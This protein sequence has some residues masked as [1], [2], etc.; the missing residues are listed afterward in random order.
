LAQGRG[1]G[2]ARSPWAAHAMAA[3]QEALHTLQCFTNSLNDRAGLQRLRDNLQELPMRWLSRTEQP[4]DYLLGSVRG[5]CNYHFKFRLEGGGFFQTGV[6]VASAERTSGGLPVPL[7]CKWKRRIKD[8]PVEIPGVTSN[9]YQISA[10]D[11]GTDICVEAQPADA[12]DGLF[13]VAVGEIGPFELDPA[14]RRS[15]DNAL[16]VGGSKFTVTQ[17]KSPG[18]TT[19]SNRQD[20]MIHVTAESVKV[21]PVQGGAEKTN[22]EIS[23]EYSADYPKVIIHPLDTSKFQLLMSES[24]T[25]HFAALSRTSRDLIALTIR[26]FHAKKYLSVSGILEALLPVQPMAQADAHNCRLDSCI[27]LERLTKELNRTMQQ[28]EVSEK[29]LRN[30]HNEKKQLQAQL[31][32]TISGFTEV[33]ESLQGQIVDGPLA[34]CPAVSVERLQDQLRE[35]NQQIQAHQAELQSERQR[36]EKLQ[37]KRKAA[38]A[39]GGRTPG[40]GE[41]QAPQLREERDLL[42]A[43]LMELSSSSATAGQ[44]DKADQVHAHELK[45]LR[46]D[47]ESLHN[48]KEQLRRQLQDQ[49]RE[50]QELQDNFLY[51]KGQLDKV[52]MKQAQ[53]AAN[54]AGDGSKELQKHRQTLTNVEEERNRLSMRLEGLL[55]EVEK[56]KAYH[57][58]SL[59]RVMTAN[60]RLLEERDRTAREVQRI[61]QLYAESVNDM[62]SE[63]NQTN[64][65]GVLRSE[66]GV[67]EPALVSE[68]EFARLRSQMAQADED[69]KRKDQENESLKN[70]IRK[71]AVA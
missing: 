22:R 8:I 43:R 16:G 37:S 5:E 71:L 15:L 42:Q 30:T 6:L 68:E 57:E 33:I 63:V 60:A 62:Q 48:H 25:F 3:M 36:L 51:V 67:A 56:E 65:T 35:S 2:R 10:D 21:V 1:Q 20:L 54:M 12:D 58:Q 55:R 29:V 61:S 9:M 40:G 28:K 59:E 41:R 11:V 49:D 18:D 31:M 66:R 7:R 23:V 53:A 50:R 69:L 24:R 45:R 52:Q 13:G 17:S 32:E 27:V 4:E 19:P 39:D 14:T 47:V 46:Q 64:Q 26:C 38:E 34:N 70:R 44:R